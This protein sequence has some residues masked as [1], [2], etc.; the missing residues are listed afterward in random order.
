VIA[1]AIVV[2]VSAVG[3]HCLWDGWSQ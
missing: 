2:Y 1:V 3:M